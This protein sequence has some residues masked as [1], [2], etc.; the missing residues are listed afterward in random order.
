MSYFWNKQVDP[1]LH[2]ALRRLERPL[3]AT[4]GDADATGD[5]QKR[6]IEI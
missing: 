2:N 6:L 3:E 5:G 4:E 1:F